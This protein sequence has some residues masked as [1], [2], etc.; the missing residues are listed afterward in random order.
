MPKHPIIRKI[1]LYLFTLVGLALVTIGCVRLVGLG[2]KTFVFTKADVYYEYPMAR[3]IKTPLII[4][5]SQKPTEFEQPTK[6]EVEEYQQKQKS[7]NRQRE[8]ADSL[9][10]IIVGLP[11]YLYHWQLIKKEKG[12]TY[13]NDS[14]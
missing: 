2:L 7:S 3:P 4:E 12:A 13:M 11:L 14:L 8:A 1:Y 5:E 9:A 10:M 6:E